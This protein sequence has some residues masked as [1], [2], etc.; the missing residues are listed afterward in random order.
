MENGFLDFMTR[1]GT[2]AAM[3]AVVLVAVGLL[4]ASVCSRL[5]EKGLASRLNRHQ[6]ALARRLLYYGILVLFIAS[7]LRELGFNLTLLLGAAGVLTVALGFASQTS[8]SN[9]IS[10]LFLVAERPFSI[11]DT[12]QVGTTV[13]EVLSVDALSI[14]L[15]T[16]DNLFVRIPNE[17]LI[18]T[19]LTNLTRFDIRRFDLKIGVAYKE[20]IRKVRELLLKVAEDNP[21]CLD[22][23]APM[24]L[25]LGF[26]ASSLDLQLSVWAARTNFF[27]LRYSIQTEVKEALDAAGIEIPFPHQSIYVGE[28]TKPFPV[29][30]VRDE[31]GPDGDSPEEAEEAQPGGASPDPERP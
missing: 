11:G 24:F 7:A 30:M 13:G 17:T 5:M 6:M 16:F 28:A 15:R 26:G 2:L 21:N 20:D 18:K 25:F 14:K 27:E 22:E 29:R 12:I 10:G 23:P 1:P 31:D 8:V 4:L 19:E 3:R 9:L